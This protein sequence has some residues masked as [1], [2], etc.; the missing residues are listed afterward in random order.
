MKIW[1][2]RWRSPKMYP[3]PLSTGLDFLQICLGCSECPET[4]F[5]FRSFNLMKFWKSEK[6]SSG[7]KS[8]VLT[9]SHHSDQKSLTPR[10][11][12]YSI[13]LLVSNTIHIWQ[14]F[15][16]KRMQLLLSFYLFQTT[17][18]NGPSIKRVQQTIVTSLVDLWYRFECP[19]KTPHQYH[20]WVISI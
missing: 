8:I 11:T 1:R 3:P 17:S 12:K 7:H 16:H 6:L 18:R 14:Q 5:G 19:I 15:Q 2:V 9:D 4:H 10:G 13:N 20:D